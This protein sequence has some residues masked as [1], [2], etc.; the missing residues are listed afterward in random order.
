LIVKNRGLKKIY[1]V[2]R[3]NL[4]PVKNMAL[5]KKKLGDCGPK[6]SSP[7]QLKETKIKAKKRRRRREDEREGEKP[8]RARERIS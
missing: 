8:K 1:T 4:G 2:E 5:K 6:R 7:N 3:D